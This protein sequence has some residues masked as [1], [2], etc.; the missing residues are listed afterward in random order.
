MPET[1]PY[2]MYLNN[3]NDNKIWKPIKS[4]EDIAQFDTLYTAFSESRKNGS[5]TIKGNSLEEL[6]DFIYNRFTCISYIKNSHTKD[7][8]IDHMIYFEDGAV[9]T[10]IHHNVGLVMVGESKNHSKSIST[11]EVAD[12][13]E[14]LR[15]R[16][17]K[18]GIFTSYNSFSR[19]SK[20]LWCRAEGKRR[21]LALATN[22]FIIGF[23]ATELASL[24][25]NN[26]Y[27]MIKQK[28][29][30]IID[31]LDNDYDEDEALE[32]HD[33][34]HEALINLVDNEIINSTLYPTLKQKIVER[35]GVL[36]I[37]YDPTSKK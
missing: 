4:K 28:H 20:S 37:E 1:V 8:Q 5:K 16:K 35:Y 32:H 21:K 9:P 31:E 2:N 17:S 25:S 18:L 3:S 7:N 11:R 24:K 12:L 22:N 13:S 23:N 15:D 36:K 19:G 29:Q 27:T 33:S 14:L 6:M 34:L 26:F 30:L 10:F